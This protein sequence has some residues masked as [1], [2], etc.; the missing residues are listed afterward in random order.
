MAAILDF[1]KCPYASI[2]TLKSKIRPLLAV[3]YLF[4]KFQKNPKN[5]RWLPNQT[6]FENS[7]MIVRSRMSI[8]FYR[9]LKIQNPSI[10][11]RFIHV[12]K[13]GN[14]RTHART[15]EAP[16]NTINLLIFD[17]NLM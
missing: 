13:K 14:A 3:L 4:V 16:F 9:H 17:V 6:K 11:S 8:R 2:D 7:K 12:C 1:F 5:P 10:I 15:H